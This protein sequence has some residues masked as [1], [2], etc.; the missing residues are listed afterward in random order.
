MCSTWKPTIKEKITSIGFANTRGKSKEGT[1]T[2]QQHGNRRAVFD[3]SAAVCARAIRD[4]ILDH[5]TLFK[6]RK[7]EHQQREYC[8]AEQNKVWRKTKAN[9]GWG[10]G[11]AFSHALLRLNRYYTPVVTWN[12][13]AY[14]T[15]EYSYR[16]E[17]SH[18]IRA[19]ASG[20]T[21]PPC[22][23]AG[24]IH[25]RTTRSCL[26]TKH[27]RSNYSMM[28]RNRIHQNKL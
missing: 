12:C 10:H 26:F 13:S 21:F 27:Q 19:W 3:D 5:A 7:R 17:G 1:A 11:V 23:R 14:Y 2:K 4:T 18:G 16:E 6:R 25:G 22:D 24:L 8:L 15:F 9:N 28:R 20:P